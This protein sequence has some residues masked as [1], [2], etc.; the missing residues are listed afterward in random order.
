MYRY[1][2]LSDATERAARTEKIEQ[3]L[4]EVFGSVGLV[5]DF[6]LTIEVI[7]PDGQVALHHLTTPN[8]TGWKAHGM[9]LYLAAA[10]A[11]EPGWNKDA[12]S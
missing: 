6:T 4:R 2:I 7:E 9:A 11:A 5:S 3:V 8:A 12:E 1:V 10:H